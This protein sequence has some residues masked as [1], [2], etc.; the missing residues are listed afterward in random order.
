MDDGQRW[1]PE[2]FRGLKFAKKFFK[3]KSRGS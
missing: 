1:M 2:D 3:M